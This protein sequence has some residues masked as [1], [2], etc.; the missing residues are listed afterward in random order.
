MS[1]NAIIDYDTLGS[2]EVADYVPIGVVIEDGTGDVAIRYT[3]EV[4]EDVHPRYQAMVRH[5]E[6]SREGWNRRGERQDWTEIFGRLVNQ[7]YLGIK[8]RIGTFIE[9]DMT[10]DEA[11]DRFVTNRE[12]PDDISVD[13]E[14][15]PSGY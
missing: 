12:I 7:S 5:L 2:F 13:D 3:V 9:D 14:R 6:P 10:V 15:V 1:K 11:F 8:F 4:V